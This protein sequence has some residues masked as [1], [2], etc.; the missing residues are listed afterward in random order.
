MALKPFYIKG[1]FSGRSTPIAGG[2]KVSKKSASMTLEFFQREKEEEKK[3]V[4]V[5]SVQDGSNLK[6]TI[7]INTSNG[8]VEH[9]IE[10]KL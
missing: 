1:E 4:Y 3:I 8:P 9:I 6:T 2:P 5:E 7:T 10:T